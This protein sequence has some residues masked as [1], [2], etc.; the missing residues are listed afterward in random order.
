MATFGH[1]YGQAPGLQGWRLPPG[2]AA[3]D[4][5][6]SVEPRYFVD[7][8]LGKHTIT[9]PTSPRTARDTQEVIEAVYRSAET[10]KAMTLPL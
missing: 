7:A 9:G 5:R 8:L 10:G 4:S 3:G 2:T 1:F 6:G